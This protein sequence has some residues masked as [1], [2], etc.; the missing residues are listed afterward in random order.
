MLTGLTAFAFFCI[1]CNSVEGQS[2]YFTKSGAV[3]FY[4]STPLENIEA[5]NNK[6]TCVLDATTGAIEMAVLLKA[7]EFDRALMQEHFNENYVESDRYPKSTFRGKISNFSDLNLTQD[8]TYPITITGS[9]TFHGVTKDIVSKG[10]IVVKGGKLNT[11]SEFTIA[12]AAYQIE[13]PSI[14]KDKISKTVRITTNL[15]L[16]PLK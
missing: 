11:T 16:D 15:W 3:A 2:K 5:R 12:L 10:K 1:L 7:F 6:G 8:G 13:I 4:A 9:L 14:V